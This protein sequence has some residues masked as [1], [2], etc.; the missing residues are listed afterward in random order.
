MTVLTY[1]PIFQS[2]LLRPI[3]NG[4][5]FNNAS[6]SYWPFIVLFFLL[7]LVVILKVTAPV[8][9]L[10]V[11]T[12]AYSLQVS[13]Q[14]EREDYS[15]FKRVSVILSA[16]FVLSL[17]FL[18]LKLNQLYGSMLPQKDSLFQFFFFVT[19]IIAVYTVKFMV[20]NVV[21][22]LS[23]ARTLFGEYVLN[24]LIINQA[25]GLVILPA[26]TVCELSD[27]NPVLIV[28]PC[29]LLLIVSWLFRL[30]R[31]FTFAMAEQGLGILQLFVYLCAL[32]ILPLL[33]MVKFLIINF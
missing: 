7:T 17:G 12:A 18:F 22:Y 25:V 3:H 31:G 26:I 5:M 9:T 21:S 32:E 28:V 6:H 4:A 20:I 24:T 15:P 8:K 10:R 13:R 29:L 19:V 16:I 14:I 27:I 30:Y 33:V 23:G 1:E 2:H 11:L